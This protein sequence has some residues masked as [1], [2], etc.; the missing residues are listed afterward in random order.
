MGLRKQVE[1]GA[2]ERHKFRLVRATDCRELRDVQHVWG[3]F[4]CNN[5]ELEIS[6][7]LTAEETSA[8]DIL[9]IPV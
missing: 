4:V 3:C 5:C 9:N 1:C 8:A 2:A 6:R 7:E